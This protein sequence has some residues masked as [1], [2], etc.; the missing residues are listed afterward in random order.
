MTS[1][2]KTK[3][4]KLPRGV[5]VEARCCDRLSRVAFG[6]IYLPDDTRVGFSSGTVDDQEVLELWVG[7]WGEPTRGNISK[8]QAAAEVFASTLP[9]TPSVCW[10]PS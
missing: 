2:S 6:F 1:P 3:P 4:L 7:N 10:R 9:W 5:Q 8:A